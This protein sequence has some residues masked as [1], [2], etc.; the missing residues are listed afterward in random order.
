MIQPMPTEL[1]EEAVDS[2]PAYQNL[3]MPAL[4]QPDSNQQRVRALLW[5]K[6]MNALSQLQN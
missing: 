1:M 4:S 2:N 5:L 3:H 6:R